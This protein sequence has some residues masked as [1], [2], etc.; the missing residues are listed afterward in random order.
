MFYIVVDFQDLNKTTDRMYECKICR[1]SCSTVKLY[2]EH[3]RIHSNLPKLRL[4][5]C[6][7]TC[8]KTSASY[9]GLKKHMTRE[10]SKQAALHAGAK[11]NVQGVSLKCGVDL[12]H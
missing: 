8:T 5:C 12:R 6:V 11:L 10:H 9:F 4:P 3:C 7:K 1:L 2:L